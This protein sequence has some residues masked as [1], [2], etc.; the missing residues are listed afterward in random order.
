MKKVMYECVEALK[1]LADLAVAHKNY[2][3]DPTLLRLAHDH[4]SGM[5]ITLHDCQLAH[6]TRMELQRRLERYDGP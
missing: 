3:G 4:E 1:P 6:H 2:W 5:A